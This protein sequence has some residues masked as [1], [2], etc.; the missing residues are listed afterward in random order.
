MKHLL[1]ILSILL[2]SS[3]LFGKETGVLYQYETSTGLV[4][5]TFGN[6]KVQPKYEGEITYGE[7]NSQGTYTNPDGGKYVVEFKDG[8]EK[9]QGT[10]TC[11]D[12]RKY[13]GEWKDRKIN[14][15]G[16]Y[17]YLDGRK[18]IVEWKNGYEHG[19]GTFTFSNGVKWVGEFS[20]TKHQY[21]KFTRYNPWNIT[22]YD[23]KGRISEILLVRNIPTKSLIS[24]D[25]F[26]RQ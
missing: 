12:G 9:G 7:P 1:I 24:E 10:Y 5:K 19:Q 11:H 4:L 8:K 26:S 17:T 21:L 18:Y 25:L 22:E 2:L 15:Q 20:S 16:T 3:P 23:K 14:G 13:I 6:G